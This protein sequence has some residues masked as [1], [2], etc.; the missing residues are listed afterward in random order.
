MRR[1]EEVDGTK[2]MGS[3]RGQQSFPALEK[4]EKES[5]KSPFL[6]FARTGFGGGVIVDGVKL[7]VR[8]FRPSR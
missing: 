6:P 8:A 4:K 1:E 5:Q 7:R 2:E 3:K